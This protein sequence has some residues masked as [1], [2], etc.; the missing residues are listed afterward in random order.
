M[1]YRYYTFHD[2]WETDDSFREERLKQEELDFYLLHPPD[3]Q[4]GLFTCKKCASQ[5]TICIQKQTRRADEGFSTFVSCIKCSY[6][7]RES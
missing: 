5:Q 3:I 2:V 7:W 6:R 4:E 1:K